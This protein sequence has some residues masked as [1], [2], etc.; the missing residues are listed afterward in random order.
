MN[1][2]GLLET[3]LNY[4]FHERK[5][6]E[7]ALTH[8]SYHKNH[9]ERLEFLGDSVLGFVVA[10]SLYQQFPMLPEGN[11]T[12]MRSSL[13][14]GHTLASIA[15]CLELGKFLRLGEGEY[16]SGGFERDSILS[17]ALEAILGA[18]Y[19]DGGFSYVKTVIQKLF[20]DHLTTI[21]RDFPKDHKTRLQERLQKYAM[22]LPIYEVIAQQGRPHELIF[23]VSC[24][25]EH[26]DSPFVSSGRSRRHAEQNAAEL[27]YCALESMGV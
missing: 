9:N 27:A 20:Q 14:K 4:R 22:P 8:R 19:L 10:N 3:A 2:F 18:I 1:D 12:R 6:L 15:R 16:K 21:D 7:Q 13:V 17:G 23:H 26:P 24:E 25:I 11:L 5:L